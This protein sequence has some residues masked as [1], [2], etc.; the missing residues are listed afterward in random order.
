M[1]GDV[2]HRIFGL[3]FG[4][5]VG[6]A[7][8]TRY[9]FMNKSNATNLLKTDTKNNTYLKI[10]G[11]GPFNLMPGQY[12][13]DSELALGI[14]YSL[15]KNNGIYNIEDIANIFL[16]W[17][18]SEPFDV[19]RTTKLA[20]G[21]INN[22]NIPNNIKIKNC[23][24]KYNF[25]SLSNGCLMKISPIGAINILFDKSFDLE[26]LANEICMLTNPNEICKDMSVCYVVAID[27]A[28]RSGD[29]NMAYNEASKVAKL[30]LTKEILKLAKIQATPTISYDKN[31]NR[32]EIYSDGHQ[33]GFIGIAFLNAFY[34]LVNTN[35]FYDCMIETIKLGGD[36]DTNCC[37]AGSLLGACYGYT[38]IGSDWI[39]TVMTYRSD[40]NRMKYYKPLNH[41]NIWNLLAKKIKEQT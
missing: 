17:F 19:G 39:N 18:S 1:N 21:M 36:V 28:L 7:L 11:E 8:G 27:M 10:K 29:K 34:H 9:E 40:H 37:I 23:A 12:T 22:K 24:I 35:N 33:Q 15:L 30:K 13:D 25:E 26:Y 4:Q 16:E 32:I 6:D 20:F 31:N 3:F 14:W 2:K 38:S 5:L 41:R